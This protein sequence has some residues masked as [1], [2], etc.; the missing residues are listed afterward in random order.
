[1]EI[2]LVRGLGRVAHRHS[3]REPV[4]REQS[5][6]C[7][8][9]VFVTIWGDR[10]PGRRKSKCKGPEAG[11]VLVSS[12]RLVWLCRVGQMKLS[13]RQASCCTVGLSGDGGGTF[14]ACS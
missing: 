9:A 5:E 4:T 13:F 3:T 6:C 11:T 10:G 2:I 1:M 14:G 7:G 12:S 8:E